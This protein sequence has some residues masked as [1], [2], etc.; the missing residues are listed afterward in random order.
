M[1]KEE[2]KVLRQQTI[3]KL[4]RDNEDIYRTEEVELVPFIDQEG[5][6]A[7]SSWFVYGI[8]SEEI[9]GLPMHMIEI[10]YDSVGINIEEYWKNK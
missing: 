5:Y 6:E 4:L 3:K 8:S 1:K 7:I 2:K 9:R 10:Q